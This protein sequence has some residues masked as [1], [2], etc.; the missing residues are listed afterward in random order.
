MW[1]LGL[2][3]L[4]KENIRG[5][6]QINYNQEMLYV[7]SKKHPEKRDKSFLSFL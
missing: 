7:I 6:Y 4:K 2:K 1:I 3:G 5:L